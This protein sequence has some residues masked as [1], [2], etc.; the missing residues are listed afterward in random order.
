MHDLNKLYWE[1]AS[2][3]NKIPRT[4]AESAEIDNKRDT[5]LKILGNIPVIAYKKDWAIW[6][7]IDYPSQREIDEEELTDIVQFDVNFIVYKQFFDNADF[8]YI[9]KYIYWI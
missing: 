9:R 3:K 7:R 6:V 5:L 8:S 4:L 1:L 2:L